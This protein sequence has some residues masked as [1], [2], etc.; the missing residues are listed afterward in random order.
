[1]H[2]G[3]LESIHYDMIVGN[4][5]LEDL[6]LDIKYS[7]ATIEW[8]GAE[9]PMRS[10]DATEKDSYYIND[11]PCLEEAAERIKQI[12]DAK[13]EPA[14]LDE[15]VAEATHLSIDEQNQLKTLLLKYESLFHGTLGTWKGEDYDI[16]LKPG[17]TPYHA[18]V[19]PIP[20]IHEKTL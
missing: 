4:D 10:R 8:D 16:E 20:H 11:T 13:Y 5:L 15:V 12:L 19:F 14:N 1:M 17:A 9:V 7:T 6:K 3:T 2:V 18:R